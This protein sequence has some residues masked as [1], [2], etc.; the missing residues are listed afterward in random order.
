MTNFVLIQEKVVF[1]DLFQETRKQKKK[2]ACLVAIWFD[3]RNQK[4]ALISALLAVDRKT[5]FYNIVWN[6][7]AYDYFTKKLVHVPK[8][9]D[10]KKNHL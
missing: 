5:L 8:K 4:C 1:L 2:L 10:N 3:L 9:N 6:Y 7:V